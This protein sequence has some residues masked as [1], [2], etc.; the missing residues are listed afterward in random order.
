MLLKLIR[1]DQKPGVVEGLVQFVKFGLIGVSNTVFSYL[2]NIAFLWLLAP[3]HIPWDYV[4][5]N[6]VAFVLSV[7][8]SFYWNSRFVFQLRDNRLR[9][10]V[11]RLLKTYISYS[12][13]GIVL[14]NLLSWVWIDHF[15]ISKY[16]AP[17]INLIVSVP[18]NF[19]INKF[20]AFR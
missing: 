6:L 9:T 1:M 10:V 20:W 12:L 8:W 5:G 18:L 11:K 16:I 19:F 7:V 3:Y 4:L 14:N 13:T 2:I 17:M 15:G